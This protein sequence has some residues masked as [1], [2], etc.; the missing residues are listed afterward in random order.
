MGVVCYQGGS[1]VTL[2]L[3]DLTIDTL[4]NVVE[5]CRGLPDDERRVWEVL[6][7]YAYV[8]EE[9][10]MTVFNTRGFHQIIHTG[11]QPIAAAGFV[12]Q[13][14][15]VYRT[16]MAAL[17]LAWEVYGREVTRIVRQ[18]IAEIIAQGIAHRVETVTLAS[19][20]RARDWY[21]KIGLQFEATHRH[22]GINGE[23]AVFYA[24]LRSEEK[25]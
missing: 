5:V 8:P 14:E 12:R 17:P 19:N 10:A 20:K 13:R 4:H 11:D 21:P 24:A 7:G 2:Q 3:R 9:A 25:G 16:W 18:G 23:D 15:G 1:P 22:Y 6:S